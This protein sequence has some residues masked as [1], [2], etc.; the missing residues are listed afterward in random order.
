MR[1]GYDAWDKGNNVTSI[2]LSKN[3]DVLNLTLKCLNQFIVKF[4]T[5]TE[6]TYWDTIIHGCLTVLH[7]LC[8]GFVWLSFVPNYYLKYVCIEKNLGR[9]SFFLHSKGQTCLL[10]IRKYSDSLNWVFFFSNMPTSCASIIWP[11]LW[12]MGFEILLQKCLYSGYF[13]WVK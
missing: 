7:I 6:N 4:Y 5:S 13:H 1:T 11:S 2:K 8:R 3:P 10:S 9:Y 12:K